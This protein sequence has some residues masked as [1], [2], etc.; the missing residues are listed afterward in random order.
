MIAARQLC[1]ASPQ[2]KHISSVRRYATEGSLPGGMNKWV[3]YGGGAFGTLFVGFGIVRYFAS[4]P[5]EERQRKMHEIREAMKQG[6]DSIKPA[7][8]TFKGGEQ[9]WVDLKL[10]NVEE[11]NHNTKKFRFALPDKD[12]VSGLEIACALEPTTSSDDETS[13]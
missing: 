11:I 6:S 8:K 1:R 7:Q 12:D 4:P 9:G 13:Y 5:P 3:K 2:F 10:E